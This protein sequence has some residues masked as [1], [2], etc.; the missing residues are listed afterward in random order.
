MCFHYLTLKKGQSL[1]TTYYLFQK[2]TT[3]KN[4]QKTSVFL[5]LSFWYNKN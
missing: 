4:L 2:G 5:V 1:S 3:Y